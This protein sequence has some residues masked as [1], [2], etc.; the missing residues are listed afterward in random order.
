MDVLVIGQSNASNWFVES[1]FSLPQ[2]NTFSWTAGAWRPV[3]GD[4]ASAFASTLASAGEPVRVLNAAVG[5]SALLPVGLLIQL[6]RLGDDA[7]ADFFGRWVSFA[8]EAYLSARQ[9]AVAA[10][11]L[12]PLAQLMPG[13]FNRLWPWSEPSRPAEPIPSR[14]SV[15]W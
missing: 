1:G 5:G 14:S 3:V 9:S 4:G 8:L 15:S 11:S 7:L 6:I 10:A 13:A 2:P 12:N